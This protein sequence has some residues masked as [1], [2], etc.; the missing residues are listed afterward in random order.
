MAYR[1]IFKTLEIEYL[2]MAFSPVAIDLT[3]RNAPSDVV[4]DVSE[5]AVAIFLPDDVKR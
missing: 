2:G 5:P 1:E 4:L 3:E